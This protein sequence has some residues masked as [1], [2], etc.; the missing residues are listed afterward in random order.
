MLAA[1][2]ALDA[3]PHGASA[4]SGLTGVS[5]LSTS[6]FVAPGAHAPARRPLDARPR[7]DTAARVKSNTKTQRGTPRPVGLG[8]LQVT[9]EYEKPIET[10]ASNPRPLDRETIQ[11][12]AAV[13]P[14]A[15]ATPPPSSSRATRPVE[16]LDPRTT[17]EAA[18]TIAVAQPD[19]RPR[20]A[21]PVVAVLP[22]APIGARR[23]E[24]LR[25]WDHLADERRGRATGPPVGVLVVGAMLALILAGILGMLL[26]GS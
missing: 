22:D 8:G 19:A 1:E 13:Q 7:G 24:P 14:S 15:A 25:S 3:R 2:A 16:P 5:V 17:T 18:T 12:L 20:A 23:P 21:G 26:S 4:V 6:A 10:A 11:E 9:G